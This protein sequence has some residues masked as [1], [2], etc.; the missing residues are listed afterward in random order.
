M[1]VSL[2]DNGTIAV[3]TSVTSPCGFYLID[4]DLEW[5]SYWSGEAAESVCEIMFHTVFILIKF[6]ANI[7]QNNALKGYFS[8]LASVG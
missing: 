1:V 4:E 5:D 8:L 2:Y 6:M 3:F 7:I